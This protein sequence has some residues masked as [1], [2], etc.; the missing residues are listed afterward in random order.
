[1]ISGRLVPEKKICE[2]LSIL[3]SSY[4]KPFKVLLIGRIHTSYKSVILGAI[5]PLFH[6]QIIFIPSQHG[7]N[8]A[9]IYNSCDFGLWLEHYSVGILEAMACGV[10]VYTNHEAGL[11]YPFIPPERILTGCLEDK[12]ASLIA[13]IPSDF[14]SS[15]SAA[16]K[17]YNSSLVSGYTYSSLARFTSSLP[18]RKY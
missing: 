10:T 7:A 17:Q 8:L 5:P 14:N 13:A 1:M 4:K 3:F 11:Y 12:I 6:S 15:N 18:N 9:A 2:I 16:V